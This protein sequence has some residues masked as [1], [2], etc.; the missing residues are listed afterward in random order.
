[1]G[2]KSTPPSAQTAETRH[3]SYER[4]K[5]LVVHRSQL[6]NA[7]YN[8]RVISFAAKRKLKR[9]LAKLKRLAP[10]SWNPTTGNIVGGHQRLDILDALEGTN[11]YTLTVAAADPPLSDAEEVEANL[12]LNAAG[13]Q[14]E[15]DIAKLEALL[16]RED[17]DLEAAGYDAVDVLRMFGEEA[18]EERPED[19][20][21]IA[22]QTRETAAHYDSIRADNRERQDTEFYCVVV[23][24]SQIDRDDFLAAK[25]LPIDRFQDGH[26]LREICGL[27]RFAGETVKRRNEKER[28]G[29]A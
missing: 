20:Q 10:E 28:L 6:N 11:D 13:A 1:M 22:D 2:K 16:R 8:P 12:A 3:T 4:F 24:G 7:P 19:L 17:I 5:P 9:S 25:G 15:D 29:K 26:E 21:K 27:G 18:L 23:F 14:G